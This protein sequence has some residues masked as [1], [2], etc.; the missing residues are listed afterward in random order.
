MRSCGSCIRRRYQRYEAPCLPPRPAPPPPDPQ[1]LFKHE[2]VPYAGL[3]G[4]DYCLLP[5]QQEPPWASDESVLTAMLADAEAEVTATGEVQ[6]LT[7]EQIMQLC[8]TT[9]HE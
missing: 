9:L 6:R 1:Q 7:D 8:K 2:V 3:V 5:V 4:S